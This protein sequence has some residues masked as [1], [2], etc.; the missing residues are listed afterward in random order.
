MKSYAA[1][2]GQI[3]Q[4]QVDLTGVVNRVDELLKQ[5]RQTSD[6]EAVQQDLQNFKQFLLD[7]L[8]G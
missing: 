2:V 3:D 1:L 7:V 5:A 6:R 8:P 4:T